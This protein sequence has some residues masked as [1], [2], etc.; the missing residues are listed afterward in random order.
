MSELLAGA[1]YIASIPSCTVIRCTDFILYICCSM[2]F[3]PPGKIKS[4]KFPVLSV[5][6]FYVTCFSACTYDKEPVLL[7]KS[8]YPDNI[9]KI[10]SAKCATAG[11]HNTQSKNGAGGFDLSTWDHLFEGGRN[12]SSVIPFRADKSFLMYFINTYR[13]LDTII[14]SPTMPNNG[15][16]LSRN[17]VITVRDWIQNGAPDCK[18]NIKFCCDPLRKKYYVCHQDVDQVTVFDSKTRLPMRIIDVGNNPQQVESAHDIDVSPDGNFW[19]INF[20]SGQYFQKFS[21]IN[22]QLIGQVYIGPGQ[23]STVTITSDS[24]YAFVVNYSYGKVAFVDL[25]Q[26]I[27]KTTF[28]GLNSPHGC[29]VSDDFKT[30]YITAQTGNYIYKFDFSN[31]STHMSPNVDQIVLGNGPVV[32]ISSLD[33]HQ[34]VI[35][36]DHTKYYVSCQKSNEVRVMSVAADT[37]LAIIHTGEQPQ[38]LGFSETHPYLFV[39]CMNDSTTFASLHSYGSIGVINYNSDVL[40]QSVFT[41][42]QPHGFNVDDDAGV[43]Y[44]ANRNVNSSG[45]APHHASGGTRNG[46]ITIIDMST[47][48]LVPDYQVE[49]SSNP[50]EVGIRK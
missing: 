39:S 12:G 16:V 49:V 23:W 46:Y 10:F 22:D 9:A 13:D 7:T 32:Y 40:F 1:Q 43:V 34:V 47:L 15:Q 28:T 50:Y 2:P 14:L 17:E 26:M 3:M 25:E 42:W 11:C 20:F 48:S 21:T 27:L 29:A 18:G 24:K 6:F 35:S 36:P 30:L 33:P 44:V 31:D 37:L 38:E 41:G 5:I 45:P 4:L 8:C 19:Y